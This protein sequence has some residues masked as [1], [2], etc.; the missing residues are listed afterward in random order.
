MKA[1]RKDTSVRQRRI[2]HHINDL[3]GP[4]IRFSSRNTKQASG[5]TALPLDPPYPGLYALVNALSTPAWITDSKG[6]T[7]A[8]NRL[9]EGLTRPLFPNRGLF[10]SDTAVPAVWKADTPVSGAVNLYSYP[11][12]LQNGQTGTL[13]VA[14]PETSDTLPN[15]A[16]DYSSLYH[17]SF[18]HHPSIMAIST[19]VEGRLIEVNNAFETM[20]GYRRENVIGKTVDELHIWV[21]PSIR[22]HVVSLTQKTGRVSGVPMQYRTKTGD[23]RNGLISAE[24]FKFGMDSLI[25]TTVEDTTAINQ[26][27][28]S[29][30]RT[31][32]LHKGILDF[33][34]DALLAI[35]T[36]GRIIAWNRAMESLTG[37]AAADMLN[38]DQYAYS[39]PFIGEPGPMLIDKVLSE[40]GDS[41][42]GLSKREHYSSL[43]GREVYLWNVA[44]PLRDGHGQIVGAVSTLR[45]VT[46]QRRRELALRK[47][48]E[49]FNKAF[50]YSPTPL[51]IISGPPEFRFLDVN[52]AF[53]AMT[54]FSCEEL[55]HHG[56]FDLDFWA[57]QDD[58][59]R[60]LSLLA[61]EL[62]VLQ[63]EIAFRARDGLQ[64]VVLCS[65]QKTDP[66]TSSGYLGGFFDITN[67]RR[68][69]QEMARL[70]R[71]NMAGEI[72]ASLGHELRNPMTTV[73]G[74]LQLMKAEQSDQRL[75]NYC[76]V[77]IEEVD[78]ANA[79]LSEFLTLAQHQPSRW[80][81]Q[82]LNAVI[83]D[84]LPLIQ[85][86]AHAGEK[87]V[88]FIA[89]DLPPLLMNTKEISQLLLNLSRNGLE[90]MEPGGWLTIETELIG[91]EAVLSI[92]DTGSG[93]PLE[94]QDKVEKPFFSTKP[95]APGLGLTTSHH[96]AA[97]HG[98]SIKMQTA[99]GG[100]TFSIH[101]P[102]DHPIGQET[103]QG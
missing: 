26:I 87:R 27:E 56:V 53:C 1:S 10:G 37:I 63:E 42:G 85:A 76:D 20:L 95:N 62:P 92:R 98:A 68:L 57:T 49:R 52:H 3:P 84:V 74:F 45:E 65:L 22:E 78:Q 17:R 60:I 25:H 18:Y 88:R 16:D 72:A 35:D 55:L 2:S 4:E 36:D 23:I 19:L 83:R 30:Q 99:S 69:E 33:L 47:S 54:G 21:D 34:P 64:R 50:R 90:A 8:E 59:T 43:N 96:I 39:V 101:F 11:I 102:L 103:V 91:M 89:Q 41:N 9:Y 80:V 94:L 75:L 40:S 13:H 71:V 77:M 29:L 46:E 44:T 31:K 93:I 67:L 97:H 24:L 5:Q 6:S 79:V 38:Q 70:D 28:A 7:V 61:R 48:E 81:R 100:T 14:I 66:N 86:N 51:M 82:N 15:P 32:D 73:R 12:P 58:R